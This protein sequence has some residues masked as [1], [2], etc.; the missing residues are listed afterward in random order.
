M[1]IQIKNRFNGE[2]IFSHEAEN[3]T[4]AIAVKASLDAGRDLSEADLSYANLSEANLRGANL[5]EANLRY[6]SLREANMRYASLREAN[7]RY[8]DLSG[9]DLRGADLSGADLRYADL[10]GADLSEAN[11]RGAD[12]SG[13]SL[14]GASLSE[15]NLRGA[16]LREANLRC[17]TGNMSIVFSMQIETYPITF[18]AEVLQIGCKRFTHQ[19]WRDFDDET[20]NKMDS[21]ALEFW[22][23]YKDFIF[24]A[25]KLRLGE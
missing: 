9:A 18:T 22:K 20:I 6:A 25:I 11:L 21:L 10:S 16:N 17:V 4:F 3:N 13:A 19:E 12:L 8:A 2:V 24:M 14:S 1:L 5:R 15:A 7:M 23:K